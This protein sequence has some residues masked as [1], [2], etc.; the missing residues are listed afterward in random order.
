M[1]PIRFLLDT[2]ALARL[3]RD[4]TVRGRWEH[5]ITAGLVAV[6]PITELEVLYTARSKT[7][8]D[9]LLELLSAAFCW[10]PMPEAV[11]ARAAAVQADLTAR[12][13]HR[14][15]GTVDLLVAATAELHALTLVHYDHDFEQI[16]A[17]TGQAMVWLAPPGSID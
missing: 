11:F 16:T 6:C 12:G 4:P 10:V 13:A 2:S 7:D 14:S 3:L 1:T 5:Q 9:E 17:V 15:A 8:R